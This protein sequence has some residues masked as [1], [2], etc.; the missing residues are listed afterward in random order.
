MQ[1]PELAFERAHELDVLP[2]QTPE[3]AVDVG[4]QRVEI[5]QPRLE[6]LTSAEGQLP[7]ERRRPL[8]RAEHLLGIGA[9]GMADAQLFG[10][11]DRSSGGL[12]SAGC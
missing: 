12:P 6:H 4:D 3:H 1:W 8:G 2:Q 5:D 11:G 10:A 7:G 9:P